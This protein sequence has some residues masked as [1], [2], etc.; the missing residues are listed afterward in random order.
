MVKRIIFILLSIAVIST[1]TWAFRKLHYWERSVRIFGY[2][3]A[4]RNFQGRGGRGDFRFEDR[5]N[6]AG[7]EGTRERPVI[8]STFRSRVRPDF[9]E[10]GTR[11]SI[12][13]SGERPDFR[14]GAFRDSTFRSRERPLGDSTFRSREG[15]GR[16][17]EGRAIFE[18]GGREQDTRARFERGGRDRDSYG[19]GGFG[20]RKKVRLRNVLWFLAAFA[21][22]TTL[23]IYLDRLHL[24]FRKRARKTSIR[25]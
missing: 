19:R 23:T 20:G 18:R 11:D 9:R 7:D 25:Q 5:R 14:D 12:F 13:R 8:D 21:G 10:R 16:E 3:T 1:G 17:V 2:T 6:R 22:F 24:F 4:D 15:S